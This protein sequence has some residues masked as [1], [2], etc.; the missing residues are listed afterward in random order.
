MKLDRTDTSS[1]LRDAGPVQLHPGPGKPTGLVATLDRLAEAMAE[2]RSW[3]SPKEAARFLDMNDDEFRRIAPQLPRHP[4]P[5]R[6]GLPAGARNRYRYYA[7]ELTDWL[8]SR[9]V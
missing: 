2:Q 9:H 1:P 5:R 4:L 6:D 8:L 3:M 7:P